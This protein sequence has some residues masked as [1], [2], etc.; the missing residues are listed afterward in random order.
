M[1]ISQAIN[2]VENI[3]NELAGKK[4]VFVRTLLT[5]LSQDSKNSLSIKGMD[6]DFGGVIRVSSGSLTVDTQTRKV[7]DATTGA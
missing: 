1:E 6:F 2:N 7:K 5:M 4:Q 3:V